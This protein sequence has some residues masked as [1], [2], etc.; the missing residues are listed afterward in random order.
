[1]CKNIQY[2]Y[3]CEEMFMVKHSSKHTCESILYYNHNADLIS[4]HCDF[5]FYLNKSILP[6]VL[7]GGSQIILANFE[8]EKGLQ[9]SSKIT[10]KLPTASYFLAD[11]S[12]TCSCTLESQLAYVLPDVGACGPS[13]T[14]LSFTYT[15]NLAFQTLIV[16]FMN[17]STEKPLFKIPDSI[18]LESPPSA[19]TINLTDYAHAGNVTSLIAL[20]KNFVH[21][22]LSKLKNCSSFPNPYEEDGAPENF[23]FSD[24]IVKHIH[25]EQFFPSLPNGIITIILAII[26]SCTSAYV[27]YLGIKLRKMHTLIAALALTRQVTS[28]NA[29]TTLIPPPPPIKNVC[30]CYDIWV[31][32]IFGMV[33]LAGV[34]YIVIKE[35]Q[36]KTLCK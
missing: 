13:V 15:P 8:A 1:M 25:E 31:S 4:N 18:L 7:D 35:C 30:V 24:V 9:C 17:I 20:S 3:F 28:I 32:S 27:I 5:N 26:S 22:F 29:Y 14:N 21:H 12:I 6:S 19:Y 34:I 33:S 11:R 36:S 16:E 23:D 10:N 2:E